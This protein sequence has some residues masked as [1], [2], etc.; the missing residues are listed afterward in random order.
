MQQILL[1][2]SGLVVIGAMALMVLFVPIIFKLANK[3]PG[4]PG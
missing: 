4:E 1:A 2:V 3:K